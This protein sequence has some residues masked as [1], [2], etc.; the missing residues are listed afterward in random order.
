MSSYQKMHRHVDISFMLRTF[1][2]ER[3]HVK[4]IM[5]QYQITPTH[6]YPLLTPELTTFIN[7]EDLTLTPEESTSMNEYL[8]A[9]DLTKTN[10]DL[11][12]ESH[13]D[14]TL[15]AIFDYLQE[16]YSK[17]NEIDSH[18][19]RVDYVSFDYLAGNN[20][21]A[22]IQH[23]ISRGFD[24]NGRHNRGQTLLHYY[25]KT[26]KSFYSPWTMIQHLLELKA[27]PNIPNEHDNRTP[28]Q[29]ACKFVD[30]HYKEQVII[31]LIEHGAI[32]HQHDLTMFIEQKLCNV[33]KKCALVGF[34]VYWPIQNYLQHNYHTT[35][36]NINRHTDLISMSTIKVLL[37]RKKKQFPMQVD[38]LWILIL[39]FVIHT[40]KRK[41][42]CE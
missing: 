16:W 34:E 18:L 17:H 21:R 29:M 8:V 26:G 38:S 36:Y 7:Q 33:V 27:D 24:I 6:L 1:L 32:I 20:V 15:R 11:L 12:T 14:I 3:E 19:T 39:S 42:I 2:E 40:K 25:L 31:S 23:L 30:W 10:I 13:R 9:R 4:M 28:L 41:K 35:L 5:A 22:S 37:Q